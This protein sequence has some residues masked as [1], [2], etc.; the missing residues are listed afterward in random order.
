MAAIFHTM[1]IIVL[2]TCVIDLSSHELLSK[3]SRILDG[4][5]P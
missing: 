1:V 2:G 4:K 5:Q 3:E